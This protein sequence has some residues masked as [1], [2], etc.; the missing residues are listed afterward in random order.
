MIDS[1]IDIVGVL[2]YV[3]QGT[4]LVEKVHIEGFLQVELVNLS[5]NV[6]FESSHVFF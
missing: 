2:L 6:E 4:V 5:E 3:V 1:G